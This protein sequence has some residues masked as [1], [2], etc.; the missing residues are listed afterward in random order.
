MLDGEACGLNVRGLPM[1]ARATRLEA[2]YRATAYV[3]RQKP[4]DIIA[5]VGKRSA[6]VDRLL[7]RLQVHSAAFV[8]AWNPASA[9]RSKVHNRA[10]H[11]RL[12]S[13]TK[14]LRLM[15]VAGYGKGD[16]GEW[17]V[18][19][20]LLVCGVDLTMARQLGRQFG[21]NAIVWIRAGQRAK[22]VKLA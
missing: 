5:R 15:T 11:K 1:F 2:A 8:T 14:R 21:Q 20:S 7:G 4:R 10:A 6:E 13:T 3:I 16:D 9:A 18:E 17:P 12:L 19:E 22:L